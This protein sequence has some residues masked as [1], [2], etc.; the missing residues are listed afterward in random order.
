MGYLL[1]LLTQVQCRDDELLTFVVGM[2]IFSGGISLY[3]K[4]SPLFINMIM[5]LA[6]ANLP[7]SK[8]RILNLLTHLEKPFYI[9][10]LILAGAAWQLGSPWAFLGALAYLLARFVGKLLGGALA[11]RM[12]KPRRAFPHG[13]GLGMI[14]QGGMVIAMVISYQQLHASQVGHVIVTMVLVGVLLS[15]LMGSEFAKKLLESEERAI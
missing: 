4:L 13:L 1:H 6:A 9:V 2:V 12:A 3:F 8:D 15:E 10:F 5:G 11:A 14:S 7:G